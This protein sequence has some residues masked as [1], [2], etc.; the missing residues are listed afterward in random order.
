MTRYTNFIAEALYNRGIDTD[1][2][3]WKT[4]DA[5]RAFIACKED[6]CVISSYDFDIGSAEP[7]LIVRIKKN[8]VDKEKIISKI[9]ENIEKARANT[10]GNNL[11]FQK[12]NILWIV[13]N[14]ESRIK[15]EGILAAKSK[16]PFNTELKKKLNSRG[17]LSVFPMFYIDKD[18][19]GKEIKLSNIKRHE[20]LVVP[21]LKLEKL[22]VNTAGAGETLKGYVFTGN[23]FD[24]VNLY[25][26]IGDELF[27]RNLRL[28]IREQ[29][30]VDEA[31]RDTLEN[32]PQYFWFRNNGITILIEEPNPI[33]DRANELVLKQA[34][35]DGIAF[36]VINGAQTI[37]AAA[38]FYFG[39]GD[40]KVIK[41]AKTAE[42]IVRVI[43]IK[44]GASPDE[45]NK[46]SISLNRQKP[47]KDEDIAFTNDFIYKMNEYLKS[48]EGAYTI[49]RRSETG[50]SQSTIGLVEFARARM[51]YIGK[52]GEARSQ[53]TSN[54]LKINNG[55]FTLSEVFVKDWYE[56][57]FENLEPLYKKYYSPIEFAVKL[58]RLYDRK[59]KRKIEDKFI[60][61]VVQNGKWYFIAFLI[62]VLNGNDQD[63]TDFTY[64]LENFSTEDLQDLAEKFAQPYKKKMSAKLEEVNSNDFKK[65]EWYN[66]LK[67][68]Y[69]DSEFYQAVQKLFKKP[70]ENNDLS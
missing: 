22:G 16:S 33:L 1:D 59:G 18:F 7:L 3:T 11:S 4:C 35:E 38:D 21:P 29:M 46:I 56:K 23:L 63:F 69:E 5:L 62:Y 27:K 24:V 52:P 9:A 6:I 32:S 31:I 68:G 10:T 50:Y 39:N 70:N 25:N 13:E 55:K 37:T 44:S 40:E 36:S 58:S 14:I 64:G 41:K 45:A 30:G 49:C 12:P 57:E 51:A 8:A 20:M 48:K 53:A 2:D 67:T 17:R 34:R 66:E 15:I 54:L 61:T 60:E 47:I 26:E 28:G 43:Q 65:S 19:S 42:V